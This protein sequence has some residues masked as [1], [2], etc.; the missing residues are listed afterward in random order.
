[1]GAQK[2]SSC[3]ARALPALPQQESPFHSTRAWVL[4]AEKAAPPEAPC[5]LYF[6]VL[7][8]PCSTRV[9]LSF[10][11]HKDSSS[12][13]AYHVIFLHQYL[14]FLFS[15]QPPE[16]RVRIWKFALKKSGVQFLSTFL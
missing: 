4:E 10:T 7:L 6:P 13:Q 5:A 16:T 14:N 15:H 12:K 3:R 9:L 8:F 1:M 11:C 2:Y